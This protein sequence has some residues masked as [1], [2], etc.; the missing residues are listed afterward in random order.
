MNSIYVLFSGDPSWSLYPATGQ[1]LLTRVIHTHPLTTS[2]HFL[3]IIRFD[4]SLL[5]HILTLDLFQ[6]L[7]FTSSDGH[8]VYFTHSLF[9]LLNL[10]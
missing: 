9:S 4:F 3:T 2:I 1:C 6:A 7:C 8:L 5:V 10:R